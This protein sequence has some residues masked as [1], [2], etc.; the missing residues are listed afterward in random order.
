V[1]LDR[2]DVNT[3]TMDQH[4]EAWALVEY[5]LDEQRAPFVRFLDAMKDPFCERLRF[6]TR[7]E[8]FA[9]QRAALQ[10]AFGT[11]A[12]GLEERWRRLPVSR[13]GR[14]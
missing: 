1:F 11:D 10:A 12:A 14:R 9:R 3:F 2:M 4:L 13:T 6:P 7:E 5:L 8:L